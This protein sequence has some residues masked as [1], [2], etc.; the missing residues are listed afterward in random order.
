M[1]LLTKKSVL[2]LSLCGFSSAGFSQLLPIQYDTLIRSQEIIAS[3]N[4]EYST[5]GIENALSSKF[6]LGGFV[7]DEIKDASFDHHK[8]INR[9][10][11]FL[12]AELEY[13]NYNVKLFKNKD[14]GIVGKAGYSVFGGM[15]YSKDTYGLA[16][17]GNSRYLGDTAELSGLDMGYTFYQK[18]GF[19]FIDRKTKSSITLNAYNVSNYGFGGLRQGTLIQDANG[20]TIQLV[21]DGEFA[22]TNSNNF[23]QGLGF[24][25]DVDVKMPISIKEGEVAY[26]QFQA[27][28]IGVAH[29][30][31]KQ[32][33]YRVDSTF[34]YSGFELNQLFGDEAVILDSISV[35]D[36]L[37]VSSSLEKRTFLL[38]GFIQV[39]KIV[40]RSKDKT[41][42]SFF[43]IRL[44]P[45]LIYVPYLYAG[46]HIKAT[47]WLSFGANVGYGGFT[48]FRGGVYSSFDWKSVSLGIATEDII[49]A[50]S[51]KG[52]GQSL[53]VRLRCAF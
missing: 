52:R 33:V 42:Q 19:G 2:I 4:G 7:T 53:Y 1:R 20:D 8:G 31:E 51:K 43:G 46:A 45:T 49:G 27:R 10:G 13:R 24:G 23:N 40:D 36:T 12:N 14:W 26:V 15:L 17:Y 30:Y 3:G 39:G 37:G 48:N 5:S 35:L 9:A 28:N 38:P 21:M 41:L 47:D 25:V 50:L 44:F 18:I 16:M 11:G 6:I 34:T 32:K 29:L 22:F